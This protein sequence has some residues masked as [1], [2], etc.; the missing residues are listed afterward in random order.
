[1]SNKFSKEELAL[2][3]TKIVIEKH[4]VD[5]VTKEN[6]VDIYNYIYDN[7]HTPSNEVVIVNDIPKNKE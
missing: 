4:D 1:M 2:S 6:I 5:N 3:L 7:L